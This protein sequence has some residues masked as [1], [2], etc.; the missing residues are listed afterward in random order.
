VKEERGKGIKVM[1]EWTSRFSG[2]E[3]CA[4]NSAV[5]AQDGRQ[6]RRSRWKEWGGIGPEEV[7]AITETSYVVALRKLTAPWRREKKKSLSWLTCH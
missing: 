2:W 3:G 5:V 6:D 1:N 4:N 7:A